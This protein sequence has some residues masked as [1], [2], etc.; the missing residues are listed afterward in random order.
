MMKLIFL[1]TLLCSTINAF[2]V[3][4]ASYKVLKGRLH[5]SG[6]IEVKIL[7]ETKAYQ[8]E[9]KFDV[10]RKDFVPVPSSVLKGTKVYEF[11][12]D[13]RT[14]AGYKNL[15]KVKT[16]EVKKAVINF[17]KRMDMGDLKAGYLIEVLP[18][19]KKSKIEIFYHP[20]LPAVGWKRVNLTLLSSLP[21]VDG[22]EIRAEL[23]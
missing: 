10:K 8:V 16:V 12:Q 1:L 7:P 9:I 17:I 20:S 13:F 15:E 2:G 18:K 22:Y 11:P 6:S 14:E 4:T 3:D 23:R 21:I 5:K 19:N